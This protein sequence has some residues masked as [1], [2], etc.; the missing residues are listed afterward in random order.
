IR[1]AETGYVVP[2][3]GNRQRGVSTKAH[4][5]EECSTVEGAKSAVKSLRLQRRCQQIRWG[6]RLRTVDVRD[7]AAGVGRTRERQYV[8]NRGRRHVRDGRS[9]VPQQM[10]S[11]LIGECPDRRKDRSRQTG[12]PNN[13]YLLRLVCW[14][15]D[16]H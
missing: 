15:Q 12:S 16:K 7:D 8:E 6:V 4:V 13:L 3:L 14:R 10:P 5:Q 9:S 2:S 1:C 11:L